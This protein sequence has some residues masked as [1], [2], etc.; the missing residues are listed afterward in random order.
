MKIH[1]R[2][3]H[4]SLIRGSSDEEEKSLITL[5]PEQ[6]PSNIK[7]RKLRFVLFNFI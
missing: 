6:M 2:D 4:S 3:K 5:I 7:M 1:P